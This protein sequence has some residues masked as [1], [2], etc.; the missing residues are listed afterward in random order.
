MATEAGEK[1]KGT[2]ARGGG[3]ASCKD[4]GKSALTTP[5]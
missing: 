5:S 3:Q 2:R 4:G 1:G